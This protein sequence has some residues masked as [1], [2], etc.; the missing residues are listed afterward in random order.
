MGVGTGWYVADPGS[1]PKWKLRLNFTVLLPK[2]PPGG[3]A[4]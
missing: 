3:G 1:G 4:R 2:V